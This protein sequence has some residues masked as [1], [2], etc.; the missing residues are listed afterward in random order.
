[1][2]PTSV[3]ASVA[4][5]CPAKINLHL[6]VGPVRA[7]GFHPLMSW[8][9]TIGLF[10]SLLM[11]ADPTGVAAPVAL[12]CD[13]ASLPSDD[14]NLV[15]RMVKAWAAVRGAAA[16]V[17]PGIVARLQK[18]TPAGAGLGGGSSD[19]ACALKAA[20]ALVAGTN[21]NSHENVAP[22]INSEIGGIN[23]TPLRP[24]S[25]ET[26]V[27]LAASVGSD[28]PFFLHTPSAVCTG[29]GEVVRPIPPPETKWAVLVL[30]PIHLSTPDV[31]R[32]F[33]AMKLGRTEGVEQQPDW[34]AWSKL[35]A[36]KLMEE[37][38]NDLEAPAFAL[39]PDLNEIRIRA[40]RKANRVF[41]MSGSG[42]SL[43]TLFGDERI[44]TEVADY[45]QIHLREF[46][47]EEQMVKVV[48]VGVNPRMKA[49]G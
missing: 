31:Y 2:S 1:M 28:V 38:V 3:P 33:D 21:G 9:T 47:I 24:L 12:T 5:D 13:P 20:E 29:R 14:T 48:A 7:D 30:P 15:V 10:D 4:V 34:A 17:V 27:A 43:F 11:R 26:L 46:G 16:Q 49:E 8:M 35:P 36:A 44:A 25:H 32:Q 23:P 39:R 19:A 42:S 40:G 18:R 41:R 45:L 6:R 22:G 37:L